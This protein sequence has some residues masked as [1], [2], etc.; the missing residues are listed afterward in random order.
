MVDVLNM[1]LGCVCKYMS[2]LAVLTSSLSLFLCQEITNKFSPPFSYSYICSSSVLTRFIP[3]F[4]ISNVL[5]A[6]VVPMI[7]MGILFTSTK[8]MTFKSLCMSFMPPLLFPSHQDSSK[9][10]FSPHVVIS[11]LLHQIALLMTFG[12]ACPPLAVA[13]L[14]TISIITVGWRILLGRYI[15]ERRVL[16]GEKT[17]PMNET[18]AAYD[19][20][21]NLSD[22]YKNDMHRLNSHCNGVWLCPQSCIWIVVI[23]TASFFAVLVFDIS[24]DENGW[25]IAVLFFSLPI[26]LF[27]II[28]FLMYTYGCFVVAAG[29]PERQSK[30]GIELS[31]TN[32]SPFHA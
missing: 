7:A 4:I 10:L 24:G 32:V 9:P 14:V 8:Y 28:F 19:S 29:G 23:S 22:A 18:L 6:F 16:A 11:K 12:V 26:F 21:N 5:L 2:F 20:D 27:P 17:K 25:L 3:V 1:F 30:T 15:K 31:T 13:I